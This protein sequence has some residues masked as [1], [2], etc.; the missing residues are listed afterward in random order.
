MVYADSAQDVLEDL[1]ERFNKVDRSKSFIVYQEIVRLTQGTTS[2][3]SYFTKL[4]EL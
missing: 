4:K 1:K 3:A 2:V